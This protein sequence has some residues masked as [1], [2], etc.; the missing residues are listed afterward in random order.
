M[1]RPH[2]PQPVKLIASIV[3]GESALAETVISQLVEQYGKTDYRSP[4]LPFTYTDYYTKEM[5]GDL[6][7]HLVSFE[8]LMAPDL[9]PS[10]KL[11]ANDMED[12]SLRDDGTRRINIDPG[13]IALEHLILATCKPFT[14]RPY[15]ADGVYADMTMVFRR[16]TFRKLEWT[17]PDYGSDEMIAILNKIRGMYHQQ[18]KVLEQGA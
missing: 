12:A 2:P 13:Y 7:R 11:F 9:L 17:F 6:F 18:R 15:L 1:S 5:G 14:H 4:P 10:I 8:Q 16:G 3:T